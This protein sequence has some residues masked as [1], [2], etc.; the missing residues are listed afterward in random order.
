[1]VIKFEIKAPKFWVKNKFRWKETMCQIGTVLLVVMAFVRS[2]LVMTQLDFSDEDAVGK[3]VYHVTAIVAWALIATFF[4]FYYLFLNN[5]L[6]NRRKKIKILTVILGITCVIKAITSIWHVTTLQFEEENAVSEWIYY[7]VTSVVWF[8]FAGYFIVY[9]LS[10]RNKIRNRR[11]TLKKV[12][13]ICLTGSVVTLFF[14]IV[15]YLPYLFDISPLSIYMFCDIFAWSVLTV[16]FMFF[17]TGWF[18]ILG[19]YQGDHHLM[20]KWGSLKGKNAKESSSEHR[21]HHH[22][23]HHHKEKE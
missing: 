22:H 18:E 5:K 20:E 14:S 16:F 2:Y 21:H 19:I 17:Y 1:M 11:E 23:H 9:N 7:G 3:V 15:H 10:V 4:V 13:L 12:F 8:L 6:Y